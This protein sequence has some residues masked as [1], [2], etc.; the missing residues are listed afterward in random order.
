MRGV[1]SG[2]QT[3]GK[4]FADRS[5]VESHR[6]VDRQVD[7]GNLRLDRGEIALEVRIADRIGGQRIEHYWRGRGGPAAM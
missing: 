1:R 7:G 6:Q 5:P 4:A 3:N 2:F